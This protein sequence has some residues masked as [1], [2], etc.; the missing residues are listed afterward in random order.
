MHKLLLVLVLLG[1]ACGSGV[2]GIARTDLLREFPEAQVQSAVVGEGDSDNVYVHVCFRPAANSRL[3]GVLC[4]YQKQ[5]AR[6]RRTIPAAPISPE[7]RDRCN[8]DA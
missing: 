7:P 8:D 1:T 5:D 3:R 6:W 4:L 2:E